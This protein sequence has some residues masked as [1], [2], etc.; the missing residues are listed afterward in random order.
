[1]SLA[2]APSS[3]RTRVVCL[4]F[5]VLVGALTLSA[6]S[7]T[8]GT[9]Q[10][11]TGNTPT[12]VASGDF[13]HDGILDLV[14]TNFSDNTVSVLLGKPD[15]TFAS[16][17][18][19]PTGN[20]PM[21]IVVADFNGDGIL[22]L[23]V[24]NANCIPSRLGEDCGGGWISLLIGR[25]DGTFQPGANYAVGSAGYP[26]T[27]TLVAADFNGDGFPDLAVNNGADK[28][29]SVL[30]NNGAGGLLDQV[31]YAVP[32]GANSIAL[33]DFNGDHKI[34]IGATGTTMSVLPGKGDGTFQPP[35]A[36]GD[37]GG[38]LVVGDFNHDGKLDVATVGSS[39]LTVMLGNGDGTFT[40][41]S[42]TTT[43][44]SIYVADLNKDGNL[45]LMLFGL[46][47][48]NAQGMSV[49][50]GNGDGTF[51]SPRKYTYSGDSGALITDINGD[52]Y[53]DVIAVGG[54]QASSGMTVSLG[55]P[56]PAFVGPKDYGEGQS[57]IVSADF[58]GDQKPDLA[59][60]NYTSVC[61]VL[62]T[63]NGT[64]GS[65]HCTPF[66][67]TGLAL[68]AGDFNGDGRQDVATVFSNCTNG[69]LQGEAAVLLGN[70][71]GNFQPPI[72][73]AV[74]LD[75]VSLA[76]GDF[77]HDGILDLAVAND[78]ASSV[79]ILIGK[80]DGTFQPHVDYPISST[81]SYVAVGDLNGDGNPDIVVAAGEYIQIMLGNGDGT[82]RMGA[83]FY[84]Y[85]PGV[86]V[87][88]DFNGDGIPDLATGGGE[89]FL[90]NG[91]GTFQSQLDSGVGGYLAVA[92]FNLD[93][94][95][96][97]A[98][99][100]GSPQ[101][102]IALGNGNG[103]FGLPSLYTASDYYIYS[104][105]ATDLN[106]DG[107]PDLATTASRNNTMSVLLSTAFKAVSPTAL[108]FGSQGTGTHSLPQ[109]VTITNI[110][111]VKFNVLHLTTI[112]NFSQ[113]NDCP[114]TLD[115]GAYCTASVTFT[116]QSTGQS[117]G[118]LSITDTT[119]S[120]PTSVPLSGTGEN[121]PYLSFTPPSLS[122]APLTVGNSSNPLPVLLENTGNAA[123]AISSIGISGPNGADF[124]QTNNCPS[125]LQPGG[126]CTANVTFTPTAGGTRIGFISISDNV[127]GSPQTIM[128]SGVGLAQDNSLTITVNGA[129]G[130]IASTDGFINCPGT[131]SH[132]YP[133]NAQVTLNVSVDLY[134]RFA[135]WNG[136]C[137]GLGSCTLTMTQNLSA[138]ATFTGP[139]PDSGMQFVPMTPCRVA[140]T[141]WPNGEWGGPPLQGGQIRYYEMLGGTCYLPS[142]AFAYAL[143]LTVIPHGHPLG[144]LTIWSADQDQ[145][146]VST[147]NSPDGRTKA[148]AAI[149]T[150]YSDFDNEIAVYVT[151]TT[152]F[153]IDVEGY[154]T[155]GGANLG[156]TSLPPC[157]LVDTRGANGQLGGPY[158]TGGVERD[159]PLLSSNC[160]PQGVTPEAYSLNVTAIPH[161]VGQPLSYLTLWP[162]GQPQPSSSLLNNLTATTVANAGLI[163]AGNNGSVAVYPSND[164][165][166][167]I[168]I[169][170]YFS[171]Y[172]QGSLLFY[173]LYPCRVLDTR[174]SGGPFTGQLNPPVDVIDN[175]CGAGPTSQAYVFNATVIPSGR[176][177]Y[178]TL[179]PDGQN[180]PTV[181]TL[182]AVDGLV[183]SNLAIVPTTDGSIDAYAAGLTQ[184][185]L[186]ISGYFA[187]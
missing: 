152:D 125:S 23:A 146:T 186:D 88:A 8:F 4:V 24:L 149:V 115:P 65:P 145:P 80:G 147:M 121:G 116:P 20:S 182:N 122:F 178:L 13:N 2:C 173:P 35:I 141:R 49:E 82:F 11:A 155:Y 111:N 72:L 9:A 10:F 48:G 15:G 172:Q 56:G 166:L 156:F 123:V 44:D 53:L 137:T 148:N 86:I 126:S 5:F 94:K 57:A 105:I 175:P 36:S 68:I 12:S 113:T 160:I 176:L 77:N 14:V 151:D 54:P 130:H 41:I 92:D 162:V 107:T 83:N 79:S 104:L 98:G 179:W 38:M 58:N 180:Q 30:M 61:A 133:A 134:W 33:G 43:A 128:L 159:F 22:D 139:P 124:S 170:G 184:L 169:N 31:V 18:T 154:F 136:N 32:N 76:S 26:P 140:D 34:D 174:Q 25:G 73:S 40:P 112:G 138:I 102:A 45:D 187:P 47:G 114:G 93:G 101:V 51:Q 71:N 171:T 97:L 87:I 106:G 183:T 39:Y 29:V 74:G 142:N 16:Q 75:P 59:A 19:Y 164:T 144:Y 63:G 60:S 131:C 28:T 27:P 37:P 7:Y 64:F 90:G 46:G 165:D 84:T 67:N 70:G 62:N 96:D 91:D 168:D 181:S 55:L 95:L 1:M 50:Y 103:T 42:N 110:S 157:R 158:L 6:Q 21:S 118:A 163:Q 3:T 81:P 78:Q 167:L 161:T 135:G 108:S 66:N 150:D 153:L 109:T 132:I 120:S 129:G 89:V 52:G 17:Q 100:Y 185:L 69:C 117:T 127:S 99:G 143:N 119:P 177:G 85:Y